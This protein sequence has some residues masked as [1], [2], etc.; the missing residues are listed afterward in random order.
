IAADIDPKWFQRI[1]DNLIANAVKYNPSGTTITVALST[2]EQHLFIVR[3]EDDGTGMDAKTLNKLFDRYYRG[4]NTLDSGNGSG[5]GMAITKQLIGL[6][7]GSIKVT[8]EVG[9]GTTVRLMVPMQ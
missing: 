8:S 2:I 3:I 4:S 5:L 7:G 9:R 1:V 6:H